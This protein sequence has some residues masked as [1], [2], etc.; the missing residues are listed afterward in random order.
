MS[1]AEHRRKCTAEMQPPGGRWGE[2][3]DFQDSLPLQ[4][5]S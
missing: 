5:D 3:C 2:T 1:M 4:A